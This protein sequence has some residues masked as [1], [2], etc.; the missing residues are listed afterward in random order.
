[1]I[2]QRSSSGNM[3]LYYYWHARKSSPEMIWHDSV[4]YVLW[5]V[6][7]WISTEIFIF[8]RFFLYKIPWIYIKTENERGN[9][10]QIKGP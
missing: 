9:Q 4:L 7:I 10:T 5:E 6:A 2:G 8:R 1:L 3:N